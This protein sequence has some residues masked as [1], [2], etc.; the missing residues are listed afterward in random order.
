M[1]CS[2]CHG[3]GRRLNPRLPTETTSDGGIRVRRYLPGEPLLIPCGACINGV[4]SCCD[5]AGATLLDDFDE[6]IW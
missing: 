1:I 2:S 4:A 6:L 5:T 3:T